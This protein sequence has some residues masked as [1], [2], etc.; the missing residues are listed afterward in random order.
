MLG[1]DPV[2]IGLVTTLNRPGGNITGINTFASELASKRL[3]LLL[4]MVPQANK[5]GFL[6]GSR[7]FLAYKEQITS[8]L[9]AGRA[10]GVEIMIVECRNDRDYDAAVATMAEG[11]A[12][13]MILGSFALPNLDKVVP[14]AALHSFQQFIRSGTSPGR[15]V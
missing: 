2:E 8:M 11:G 13:G 4:K 14:L 6:S 3:D 1:G 5:I 12:G 7:F 9:A 10:L 15:A